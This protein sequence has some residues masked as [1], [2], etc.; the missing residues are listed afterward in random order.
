M[1]VRSL[2]VALW[3]T[4][5]ILL[6]SVATAAP[7]PVPAPMPDRDRVPQTVANQSIQGTW[8]LACISFNGET[9]QAP[10]GAMEFV[11]GP[12]GQLALY[13]QGRF[14]DEGRY[15]TDGQNLT[16]TLESDKVTEH[17][18]F[19]IVNGTLTITREIEPGQDVVI[20]LNAAADPESN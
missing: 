12:N 5:F 11:F 16:I 10:A 1:T 6:A 17:S 7:R 18:T 13:F 15:Q 19:R 14:A 8:E 4:A 20:T 2:I 3:A 9:Q